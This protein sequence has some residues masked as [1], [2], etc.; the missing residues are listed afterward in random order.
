MNRHLLAYLCVLLMLVLSGCQS[1]NT[2]T[3]P[4]WINE[5][6]NG[7]VGSATTHVKGRYYQEELAIARARERLAARY[8]VEVGSVQTIRERVVNGRAYVTSDKEM[9]QQVKGATVKAQ[10]REVWHDAVRDEI[11]VWVYPIE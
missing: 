7:A 8:G 5:P 6:G 4:G 3:P 10:V 2:R 9:L 1:S 11:W